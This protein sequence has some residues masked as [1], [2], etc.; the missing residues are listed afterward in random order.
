MMK[1][2]FILGL[3]L[4]MGCGCS[5]Y[6]LNNSSA[7]DL[8][9]PAAAAGGAAIGL[10]ATEGEDVGTQMAGTFGGGILGWLLGAFITSHAEES[11]FKEF[12]AGYNLGRSNAAKQLY[13]SYQ[14]LHDV[15]QNSGE[16]TTVYYNFPNGVTIPVVQ[17]K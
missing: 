16:D 8:L 17:S 5:T 15:K 1:V 4:T 6:Q 14:A 7:N 10:Y 13:W 3:I 9:T 12:Q 11:R 2:I